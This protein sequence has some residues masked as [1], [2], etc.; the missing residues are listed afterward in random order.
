MKI[1]KYQASEERTILTALI[2]HDGVLGAV[3][4]KLGK[5]AKPFASRW[6]N[7]IAQWCLSY[8]TKY[9]RAPGKHIKGL[10][11]R[12]AQKSADNESVELIERYLSGLSKE[13]A[14]A[15]EINEKFLIDL[16]SNY[17]DKVRLERLAEEIEHGIEVSDVDKAREALAG[18]EH[19]DFSHK[20][21]L[22]PF[23]NESI[24]QTFRRSD[25]KE[26]LVQFPGALGEFLS[27]HFER[28]GFV[29]FCGP[30]KRGKSFWLQEV[31]WRALKQRRRVLYYV[32]GDMSE[33]EVNKRLYT[34]MLRRPWKGGKVR[35]PIKLTPN[36]KEVVVR[37]KEKEREPISP[38]SV[39]E[40]AAKLKQV[41]ASKESRLRL[42]CDGGMLVSAGDIET[43][44][45]KAAESGWVPD[46][47]VVDYA[48]LL[49]P[50]P[51]T[52]TQDVRHQMNMSWLVLRR[53]GLEYGCLVVTATQTASTAYGSWLI[54]KRDFSE[55]KRK[56]A[57]VTGMIGINQTEGE[58]GEKEK[59]IYRL[60]WVV[61]RNGGWTES[62]VCWTAGN[63]SIAIPCIL[64]SF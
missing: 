36:G 48:D 41:C 4:G 16:A 34:R 27:P 50:E 6:S 42:R 5:A 62:Q 23:T 32:F 52:R 9:Q 21:W 38:R 20:A 29:S 56:N 28:S 39:A 60:N 10:F 61:L 19:L 3:A 55:D 7:H 17:F 49:S 46:V 14:R 47:V 13:Y 25:E 44:V 15:R 37:Y 31:V 35:L 2:T 1:R 33:D 24:K 63:L 51:Q 30:D 45:K 58:G 18:Y 12:F 11:L 59:G 53:I 8:Y 26:S 64:S 57:H 22:D 40:A 54:R 43:D